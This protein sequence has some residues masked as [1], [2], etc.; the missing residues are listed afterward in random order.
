[1]DTLPG[2]NGEVIVSNTTVHFTLVPEPGGIAARDERLNCFRILAH[3][4][5]N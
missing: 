4:R 3:Y 2:F 1:M 5:W